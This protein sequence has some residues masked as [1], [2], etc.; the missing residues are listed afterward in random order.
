MTN[1]GVP[2]KLETEPKTKQNATEQNEMQQSVT[3]L[4]SIK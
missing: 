4:N 1:P 2:E 3:K